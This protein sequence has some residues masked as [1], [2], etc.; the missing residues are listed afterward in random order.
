M[1]KVVG[2]AHMSKSNCIIFGTVIIQG[3]DV[4]IGTLVA[5][6]PSLHEL[7]RIEIQPKGVALQV[8]GN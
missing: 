4:H 7:W 1:F 3:C 6:T 2:K 5:I 8:I